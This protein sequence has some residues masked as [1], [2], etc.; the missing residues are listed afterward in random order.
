M[1]QRT[2]LASAAAALVG[3]QVGSSI[4]ATRFVIE[5]TQPASLA[6]LRYSIGVLFL[7]PFLL[8]SPWVCLARRDVIPIAV[9]GIMQFAIV[10]ALLNYALQFMSSARAALIFATL[11]L[12]TLFI[13]ALLGQE[14]L[15]R[16]K[17]LGVILTLI[18]VG[19]VLGE[20]AF[21][22]TSTGI[23]GELT[24][25][26]SAFV[27]ALC[28]VLYRPYLQKYPTLQISSLAM[29]ASVLFLAYFAIGEHFFS[30]L[31]RF[32]LAGWLAV[33]FIGVGSG[34]GYFL[35]LWAL[36]HTTPTRVTIFL[37]LSPIT[38]VLLGT[39][40]LAEPLNILFAFALIFVVLGLVVA[41]WEP[42]DV[43]VRGYDKRV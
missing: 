18:G 15:T 7:L 43:A 16:A 36:N 3:V 28:S 29:L 8:K 24:V 32:T 27:G 42:V 39:I 25:L 37:A 6:L 17:S 2:A 30:D 5:Q 13:A 41:H 40:L 14:L 31:P 35:W 26:L 33:V 38:A 20:K 34:I 9:L 11:P 12:Q 19:C 22:A 1:S 4:V 10:V 23:L 21:A